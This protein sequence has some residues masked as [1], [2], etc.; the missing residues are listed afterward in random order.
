[1]KFSKN[2]KGLSEIVV[3]L[4]LVALTIVSVVIVSVV[5]NNLIGENVEKSED[6]FGNFGKISIDEKYTCY[7]LANNRIQFSL[8]VG[9]VEIDEL[10]VSIST[11]EE[12]KGFKISNVEQLIDDLEYINGTDLVRLPAMNGGK[13]YNYVF[14]EN[15][16]TIQIAPIID[17]TQCEVS[18][19]V[20]D[21]DDCSLLA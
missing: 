4:I 5:V 18:D 14:N 7:D 10:L 15:P 19:S 8:S 20:T 1:M 16:D 21:I 6:C 11:Q 12:S 13:T 2:K 9:D 3:S 17:G